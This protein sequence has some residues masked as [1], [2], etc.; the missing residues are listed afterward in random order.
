MTN[1]MTWYENPNGGNRTKNTP[2]PNF[3]RLTDDYDRR[4]IQ[5]YRDTLNASYPT[6]A[7]AYTG[8]TEGWPVGH[9]NW[10]PQFLS[11][12]QLDNVP[13]SFELFQNY[14]NPFNPNTSIKFKLEENGFV[15]L[16]VYNVLGQK[17]KTLVSEELTFGTHQVDFDASALSSGVYFYK[18]E[19]GKQTSVRKMMLL[20]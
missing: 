14:P 20:K 2:S 19:S 18:L 10:F 5:Y 1:M 13:S 15:T 16:N 8:S 3:N 12:E 6:T 11:V 4:V 9:L 7:A 17:V